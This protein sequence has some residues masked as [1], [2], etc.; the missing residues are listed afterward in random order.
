M[1]KH[2][3]VVAENDEIITCSVCNAAWAKEA[4]DTQ[5]VPKELEPLQDVLYA[6]EPE[7]KV[8]GVYFLV[9]DGRVVYVGKSTHVP[10]RLFCHSREKPHDH[11][12]IL[13]AEEQDL[14]DIEIS[15]IWVLRPL[16]NRRVSR[17]PDEYQKKLAKYGWS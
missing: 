16:L 15:L 5:E 11:V 4:F 8:C 2:T 9:R 6:Q 14:D 13:Y 7:P 17:P 10:G 1:C 3:L 12:Y